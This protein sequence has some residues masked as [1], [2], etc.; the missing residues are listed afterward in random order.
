MPEPVTLLCNA[1]NTPIRRQ[2]I[3][4][5]GHWCPKCRQLRGNNGVHV[6]PVEPPKAPEPAPKT[7]RTAAVAE[8]EDDWQDANGDDE[9][10]TEV[11]GIGEATAKKL[12]DQGIHTVK[13]L[14]QALETGV[15]DDERLS[16]LVAA[17]LAASE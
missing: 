4:Q 3:G 13:D 7:E 17:H 11:R 15:V 14:A 8:P 16:E 2:S 1:C 9:D 5:R 10:V 12:A 6:A